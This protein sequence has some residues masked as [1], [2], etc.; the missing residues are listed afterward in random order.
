MYRFKT[1][2]AAVSF[3]AVS[4]VTMVT[5]LALSP[6]M[7]TCGSANCFLVTG[8]SEGVTS[9]GAVTFD[10][11]YRYIDQSHKLEGTHSVGEVL[12]PRIDF[13]NEVIEQDHHREIRTQN[14]LV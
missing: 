10:L 8:S 6:V 9:R 13:E 2:V 12:A 4:I 11:S 1:L 7:A 3:A 14:T 5:M